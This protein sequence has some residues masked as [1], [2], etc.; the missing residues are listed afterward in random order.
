MPKQLSQRENNICKKA[1]RVYLDAKLEYSG[2]EISDL[3]KREQK[4]DAKSGAEYLVNYG[5]D[6]LRIG[7]PGY[8]H[9]KLRYSL[10]QPSHETFYLYG[11]GMD[12][13]KFLAWQDFL[14]K[15]FKENK[16]PFCMSD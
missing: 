1:I 12:R 14:A 6:G 13:E 4:L 5:T 15:K 2:V 16:L 8:A 3:I 11:N 9:L 10:R 7:A